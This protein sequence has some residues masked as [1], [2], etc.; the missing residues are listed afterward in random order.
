MITNKEMFCV[1]FGAIATM[2]VPMS[3]TK[4]M[5][6]QARDEFGL[7]KKETDKMLDELGDT[8]EFIVKKLQKKAFHIKDDNFDV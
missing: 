5:L 7:T 1:I 8:L 4:S 2:N 6:S 3:Y